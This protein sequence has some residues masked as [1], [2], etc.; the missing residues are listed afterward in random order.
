MSHEPSSTVAYG[1][2]LKT[3]TADNVW[4]LHTVLGAQVSACPKDDKP[5]TQPGF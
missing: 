2:L 4:T 5:K 3:A 1:F